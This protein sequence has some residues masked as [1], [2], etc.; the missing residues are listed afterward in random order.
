VAILTVAV[1]LDSLLWPSAYVLQGIGRHRP[2]APIAVASAI[3]NVGC[4]VILTARFGLIGAATGTLLGHG[5]AVALTIPWVVHVLAVTPG[6]LVRR[7]ALPALG[8]L[9]PSFAALVIG[10]ALLPDPGLI[11]IGLIAS[12]G[13]AVY[14]L[15]YLAL[16]ASDLERRVAGDF[17]ARALRRPR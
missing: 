4:S 8:P 16:G 6:E 1:V 11:G 12:V 10:R 17:V 15:V 5:L 7:I 14:A 3:V 13:L 9:V 2:L